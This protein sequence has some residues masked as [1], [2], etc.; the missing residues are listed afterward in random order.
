MPGVQLG[1]GCITT[2]EAI[3]DQEKLLVYGKD[4]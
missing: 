2:S 4:R 3:P 1:I